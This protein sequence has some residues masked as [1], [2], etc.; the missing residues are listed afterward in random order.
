MGKSGV[1]LQFYDQAKYRKLTKEQRSKFYKWQ[2]EQKAKSASKKDAAVSAVIQRELD[3]SMSAEET[4]QE[5]VP[6]VEKY[7]M[8]LIAKHIPEPIKSAW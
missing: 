6:D 2:E 1:E 5:D 3:K 7:I 4:K 8:S